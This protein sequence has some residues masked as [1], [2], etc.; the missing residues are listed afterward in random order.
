MMM[1]H[2]V[3]RHLPT[4]VRSSV[5][6]SGLGVGLA[7]VLLAVGCS[8]RWDRIDLHRVQMA[9]MGLDQEFY[10]ERELDE[11]TRARESQ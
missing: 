7:T 6:R 4:I 8:V 10:S 9:R 11:L 5:R 1:S 2:P 3:V